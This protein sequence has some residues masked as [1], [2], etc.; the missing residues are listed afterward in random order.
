MHIVDGIP[1]KRLFLHIFEYEPYSFLR[2]FRDD[3]INLTKKVQ[4]GK[5]RCSGTYQSTQ[6]DNNTDHKRNNKTKE[7]K[8][9][10]IKHMDTRVLPQHRQILIH[11]V[12]TTCRQHRVRDR[13]VIQSPTWDDYIDM[14]LST[15]LSKSMD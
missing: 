9:D 4:L 3:K 10:H 6:S 11:L 12:T 1:T 2:N 5:K 13:V 8:K 7:N 15:P 14:Q